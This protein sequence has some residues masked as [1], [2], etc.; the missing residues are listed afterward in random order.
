MWNY[1]NSKST[2]MPNI[3]IQLKLQKKKK[4]AT[5]TVNRN[6]SLQFNG[7]DHNERAE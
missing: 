5:S 6:L 7:K 1:S 3:Q 4:H 2:I